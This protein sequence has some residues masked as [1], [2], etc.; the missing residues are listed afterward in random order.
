MKEAYE[1]IRDDGVDWL[2]GRNGEGRVIK[3]SMSSKFQTALNGFVGEM[4]LTTLYPYKTIQ[5]K[6]D[7]IIHLNK[8]NACVF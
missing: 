6:I 5:E 2:A 1:L 7:L 3:R 8:G 4:M